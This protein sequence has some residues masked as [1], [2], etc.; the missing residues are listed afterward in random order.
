VGRTLYKSLIRQKIEKAL[1]NNSQN[2]KQ[3]ESNNHFDDKTKKEEVKAINSKERNGIILT[4]VMPKKEFVF[5]TE[6]FIGKILKDIKTAKKS[7]L[8]DS[9]YRTYELQYF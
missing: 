3:R 8:Q 7:K 2:T 6:E 4:E 9:N 1:A 5:P